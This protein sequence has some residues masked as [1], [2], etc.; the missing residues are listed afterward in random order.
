M[1][2]AKEDLST[3]SGIFYFGMV[4]KNIFMVS[5]HHGGMDRNGGM[6]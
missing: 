3:Q 4:F 2:D 5:L 6:E 1:N